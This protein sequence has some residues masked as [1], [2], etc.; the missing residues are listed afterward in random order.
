MEDDVPF[1][2]GDV[3]VPWSVFGGVAL[4]LQALLSNSLTWKDRHSCRPGLRSDVPVRFSFQS[5][6]SLRTLW[7]LVQKHEITRF[8]SSVGLT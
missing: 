5:C 7:E 1:Q 3:Q 8:D 6:E 2:T 4:K